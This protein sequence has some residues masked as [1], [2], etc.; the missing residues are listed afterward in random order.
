MDIYLI[1]KVA[2]FVSI[3]IT[4]VANIDPLSNKTSP[5]DILVVLSEQVSS[6]FF[7]L[8]FLFFFFSSFFFLKKK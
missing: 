8:S 7:F 5:G 6:Y 1:H 4:N 3:L 2:D